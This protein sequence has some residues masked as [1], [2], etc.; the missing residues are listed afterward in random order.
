MT[1]NY[2]YDDRE[3]QRSPTIAIPSRRTLPDYRPPFGLIPPRSH[4]DDD[5]RRK[6]KGKGKARTQARTRVTVREASPPPARDSVTPPPSTVVFNPNAPVASTSSESNSGCCFCCAGIDGH[7]DPQVTLGASRSLSAPDQSFDSDD[8]ETRPHLSPSPSQSTSSS[9]SVPS[10]SPSRPPLFDDDSGDEDD[11]PLSPPSRGPSPTSSLSLSSPS[12]PHQR[13]KTFTA[14]IVTTD[15]LISPPVCRPDDPFSNLLSIPIQAKPTSP[16]PISLLTKSL[17]SL[18][19]LPNLSLPA[20]PPLLSLPQTFRVPLPGIDLESLGVLEE[21]PWDWRG[22][23]P[24]M[25]V[26]EVGWGGKRVCK[27][28]V[29][30]GRAGKVVEESE[31]TMVVQLQTFSPPTPKEVEV[32][33]IVLPPSLVVTPPPPPPPSPPPPRHISNQR[34]LLMLSLEISM[35]RQGKIVSPLRQRTVVVRNGA[36]P[37]VGAGRRESV[38]RYECSL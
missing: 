17:R 36:A 34:H 9:S 7:I 19:R 33:D 4:R 24:G 15:P 35:M 16:G 13:R 29:E 23:R 11:F 10:L 38:L 14:I 5:E 3:A 22:S 30:G 1:T 18:T 25:R 8:D 32:V 31:P 21:S 28:G 2:L 27:G 20:L 12:P 6:K 37:T 26:G